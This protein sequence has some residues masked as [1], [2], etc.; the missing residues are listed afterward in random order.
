MST[1]VTAIRTALETL[2]VGLNPAGDV[3]GHSKYVVANVR[4]AWGERPEADIDR[5]FSIGDI[6]PAQAPWIG[7]MTEELLETS[8][9]IT[10]GHT[11]VGESDR[12][13]SRGRRDRDLEQIARALED[14]DNYPAD[15]C[16]IGLDGIVGLEE[17]EKY[18]W[19]TMRFELQYLGAA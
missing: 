1:T 12:D 9:E 3:F 17:N 19:T 13:K 11:Q 16:V 15:V 2:I 10:V 18:W 7:A 5:E 4:F 8:F 14:P 6:P